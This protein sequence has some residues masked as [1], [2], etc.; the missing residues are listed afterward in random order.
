MW[1]SL[2]NAWNGLALG[3]QMSVVILGI[4]GT[5]ALGLS[6]YAVRQNVYAPFLVDKGQIMADKKTIGLTDDQVTEQ[7]KR[8]DTDGDGLSDWDEINVYHTNP[9][10]YDS[11]GDGIPDNIRVQ[12]GQNLG[13]QNTA[14][15]AEGKIDLSA[16]QA[17]PQQGQLGAVPQPQNVQLF[18][19][20]SYQNMIKNATGMGIATSTFT[21]SSSTVPALARDPA[22]IRQFL[23]G[24]VDPATL[25]QISD[26]QL[27][28]LFDNA[29]AKQ[30]GA[31]ST[32]AT[33][34]MA[35]ASSTP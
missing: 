10:L 23:S 33:D 25:A 12:T 9:D 14:V 15:N 17:V 11:C 32:S 30:E 34:T 19:S 7:Q 2:V 24:K 8:T 31:T 27:L 35:T 1:R 26:A 20:Q 29:L 21:G 18:D 13:C 28:V 22:T 4:C 6:A 5:L 16:L 3:Q